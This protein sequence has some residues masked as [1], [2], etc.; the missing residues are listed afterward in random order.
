MALQFA[1]V[2]E[3]Q[4][5]LELTAEEENELKHYYYYYYY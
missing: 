2:L 5:E 3:A 1:G 4:S